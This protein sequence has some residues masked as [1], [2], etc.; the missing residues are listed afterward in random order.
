VVLPPA[1]PKSIPVLDAPP[2]PIVIVSVLPNSPGRNIF[3]LYA[4]PP[5]PA[6]LNT[7]VATPP[8]PPPPQ[9]STLMYFILAG[10][11]HVAGESARL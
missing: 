6:A 5:P 11:V 10:F 9:I 1:N 4:P 7:F 2:A 3:I 8:L